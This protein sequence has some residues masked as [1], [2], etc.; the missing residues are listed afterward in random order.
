MKTPLLAVMVAASLANPVGAPAQTY[1]SRPVTIIV[2]FAAGG[3][4]DV[5]ARLL[6][7]RMR[8]PLG[9]PVIIE[10][11]TGAGGSIGVGRVARAAPDGHTVSIGH[12]GTHVA[13]GALYAL[14]YDVLNDFEPISLVASFPLLIVAKKAM[15]ANDLKELLAWLNANPDKASQG[16]PGLGSAGH[17]GGILFQNVTG[18]RF[19]QVPYRGLAPAL[20]DLVA[21]QIDF[22][23]G[24]PAIFLPQIRAGTIKAYAVMDKSRLA[25]APGVPTVDEAG[26]PG[27]HI[28]NWHGLWVPKGTPKHVT[29]KLNAAVV[30]ALAEPAVRA[31]LVELGQDIFP[32]E[33]QTPQALHSHQKGEIE[34]WWPIIKAANIKGE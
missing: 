23:F 27:S 28:T 30:D 5:I 8:G 25:A 17:V 2:P 6:A 11:V 14:P 16:I 12:W 15:P 21:G 3:A 26:L 1:P 10:G 13:N 9:Q 33:Q 18:A 4:T 34:K 31:R 29:A 32:R 20:Q 24:D 22:A 7:E 19:Q